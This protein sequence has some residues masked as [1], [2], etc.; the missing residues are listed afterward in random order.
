MT[1]I[2][3]SL[4]RTGVAKRVEKMGQTQ[5]IFVYF[6]P[7]FITISIKQIEKSVDGVLGI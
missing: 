2:K 7:F 6:R 3:S 5:P 1:K 4:G